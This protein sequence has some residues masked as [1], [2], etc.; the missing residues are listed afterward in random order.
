MATANSEHEL[1]RFGS[2]PEQQ[3]KQLQLQEQDPQ[4]GQAQENKSGSG[5]DTSYSCIL[6]APIKW[7]FDPIVSNIKYSSG[8]TLFQLLNF[9]IALS[10]FIFEVTGLAVALSLIVILC[11]GLVLLYFV[12]EIALLFARFDLWVTISLVEDNEA[13][14][15]RRAN[16]LSISLVNQMPSCFVCW[17]HF[18]CGPWCKCAHKDDDN[19]NSNSNNNTSNNNIEIDINNLTFCGILF[20]RVKILFIKCQMYL[21]HFYFLLIKPIVTAL[22]CWTIILVLYALFLVIVPIWY[23]SDPAIF[24]N[25]KVCPLS[26]SSNDGNGW[27]C[28]GLRITNFGLAFLCFLVGIVVLPVTCRINSYSA[29]L[30]KI[31]TYYFL[32]QYYKYGIGGQSLD[33]KQL[34]YENN[35]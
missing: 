20:R 14:L 33:E 19:S 15:K 10:V 3:Q 27:S 1:A 8:T 13:L 34:L 4:Q 25:G 23:L 16:N 35:V 24:E 28:H 2:Q 9:S 32:T 7:Y 12:D 30:S 21:I 29:S 26:Y 11:S 17:K 6:C 18:W 31:V 22:T 5:K